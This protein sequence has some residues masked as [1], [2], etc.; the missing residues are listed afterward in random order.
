MNFEGRKLIVAT[1]H[2]KEK[3]IAPI[4][5]K[6]LNV[7]CFVD[8]TFDSDVFGTFT[9]EIERL[10][11][12]IAVLRAK[13]LAAMHDNNCDLGIASEGSFGAHPSFFFVPADDELMV[14][15]DTKNEIE[16]IVRLL[17]ADTNFDGQEV[18]NL[19]DLKIFAEKAGFPSHA[20]ILKK[21]ATDIS[22]TRKGISTHNELSASFNFFV[23]EFS[24]AYVETD[25]R[26]MF[27]PTR[28]NVIEQLTHKLVQKVKQ[29]CPKC[30]NPGFDIVELIAGLPCA[31]C[32]MPTNS[33]LIHRYKCLKCDHIEDIKFPNKKETEDPGFCNFCNP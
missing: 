10:E 2:G 14:L 16:I 23:N 6:E 20:L 26:A 25:M 24:S 17:T 27:N 19:Q 21:S 13:C 1:K 31:C 18:T 5:E 8:S 15:I 9:G 29:K 33:T 32:Q 4:L 7:Q 11:D 28:M 22:I 30:E 3:V 12:P